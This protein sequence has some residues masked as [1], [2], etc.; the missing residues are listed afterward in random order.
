MAHRNFYVILGVRP[1][2]SLE[3]IRAAYRSLAKKHHPDRRGPQGAESFRRLAEAY[4]VLSDPGRRA[5]HN[6]E[7]QAAAESSARP[8]SEPIGTATVIAPEP[9]D[10]DG[11]SLGRAFHDSRSA[12]EAEYFEWIT[13]HHTQRVPKSGRVQRIDLEVVLSP[14]EARH[15]GI[16]P[17]EIPS[18]ARCA[19]CDGTGHTWLYLCRAC[20]GEGIRTR[21]ATILVR[22]PRRADN[23]TVRELPL[24]AHGIFLRI[25]LRVAAPSFRT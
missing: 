25:H 22:V 18:L 19:A 6:R 21:P 11:V 1:G 14:E 12:T 20:G 13:R 23:G 4:E 16:L 2:A 24:T 5:A 3:D 15:G 7:I 17:V 10:L 9:V 8:A